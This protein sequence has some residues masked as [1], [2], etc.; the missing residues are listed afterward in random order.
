MTV[1]LVVAAVFLIPYA[2]MFIGSLKTRSEILSVPP[3]YLPRDGAQWSNYLTMWDTPE[4]PVAYNLISTVVIAVAA[5]LLVLLVAMPAA[6]Y[7]ARFKYRGKMAFMFL[8]I[9]TQMLQPAILT[10][11]LFKEML[12]FNLY[13]TWLAMILINAAFNLAFAVWIMHTF[14]AGVPK[15]VDEAAQL[16]GAGKLRVLFTI[17][18][19][20]VW[21]GIVTAL[22]FTFV[23]CWNEFAASLVILSTAE[24]QPLSVALTR[25]VG[26]YSTAWQYVFGV[27][28]VAI[29]PVIILFMLIEKRLIGGLAA[30]ATK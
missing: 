22:I 7:S 18:L 3:D 15:E 5:T 8:V 14:F 9:V 24:N 4:T 6:Y 25:F 28:I 26:Q 12:V 21:P 11:G 20:L 29:V 16:D 30:G 27:S 19:P 17:N 23:A 13:D 10:V 2:V 1:G